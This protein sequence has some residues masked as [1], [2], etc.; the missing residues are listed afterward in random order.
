MMDERTTLLLKI[1]T[2]KCSE[3]SYKVLSTTELLNEFP[4][5]FKADNDLIEL[6]ITALSS[7][8][9][10]S[11][12]FDKDDEFCICPTPKGREYVEKLQKIEIENNAK[13][14]RDYLNYLYIFL[15]VFLGV[16][17]ANILRDIIG[18]IC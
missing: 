15:S 14:G 8:A 4:E 17:L 1:I 6:M 12:K 3:G 16:F 18:A 10:I 11:V 2:K 13:V 5:N 7:E 9:Y